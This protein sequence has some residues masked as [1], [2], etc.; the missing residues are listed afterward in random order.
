MLKTLCRV[1]VKEIEN[2]YIV[3]VLGPHVFGEWHEPDL[4]SVVKRLEKA[5]LQLPASPEEAQ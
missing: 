1:Y 5:L 2:G 3:K 4:P